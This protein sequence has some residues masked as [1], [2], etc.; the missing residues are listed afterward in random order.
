[1]NLVRGSLRR[2]I[3]VIV[4]ALGVVLAAGLSLQKTPRDILP[5]LG[6]P[7]IYVAQPYG[8]MSPAQMEGY[9]PIITS[10]TSSISPGSSMWSQSRSKAFRSSNCN[11]TPGRTW[12]RRWRR[13]SITPTARA[14]MPPGTPD[15]V[16]L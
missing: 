14:F 12:P 8:G 15:R 5:T 6:V 4:A 11:S 3:T 2:P 13:R 16:A 1:M 7:I 9:S 10:I